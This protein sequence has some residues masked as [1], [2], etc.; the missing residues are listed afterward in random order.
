MH[1]KHQSG[2]PIDGNEK[3]EHLLLEFCFQG[4]NL[5]PIFERSQRGLVSMTTKGNNAWSVLCIR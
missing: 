1:V 5:I 3:D 4:E 2:T